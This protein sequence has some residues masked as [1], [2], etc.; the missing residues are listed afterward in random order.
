MSDPLPGGFRAGHWTDA[1]RRTGCTVILAGP[2]CVGAADVR[3]GAPGTRETQ[4]FV[5]GNLVSEIHAVVLTGGSAFGLAA[6]GGVSRY[7]KEQGVGYPI[8]AV[9]VP[10]VTAAVLFDL[11][12]GDPD[13]YPDEAA[14]YAAAL[15]AS[16]DGPEEGPAGAGAG[17]T[18]GKVLGVERSSRGGVGVS[19]VALPAGRVA[20]IAAVNAFGDVVSEDGRIL[21]GSRAPGGGFLD[22]ARALRESPLEGS[23]IAGAST[24]LVCIL[25]DIAFDATSLRRVAIEAHDGLARA[26]RPVHTAVDGDVVFAMAPRGA[27]PG[28]LGRLRVGEAAAEAA[29]SA[30]RRAVAR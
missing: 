11:A 19:Q 15:G 25:T 2:G 14:G 30:V 13:A 21:A 22:T 9:R 24:T 6:A 17:A 23:P 5:P 3:G 28:L 16:Q 26:I 29:A 10:I 20:A 1:A 18:V 7:L 4:A 12:V 27:E 8:G